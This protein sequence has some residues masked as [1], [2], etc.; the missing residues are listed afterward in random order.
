M[1]PA[2]MNGEI[3]SVVPVRN[4]APTFGRVACFVDARGR[5]ALHRTV[6]SFAILG[7]RYNVFLSDNGRHVDVV[8][9][10]NL[11]GIVEDDAP[12]ETLTEGVSSS[13]VIPWPAP[14]TVVGAGVL[15][16]VSRALL[17]SRLEWLMR[18]IDRLVRRV[19][20][21]VAHRARA[22]R[23]LTRGKRGDTL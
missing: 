10:E 9:R 21:S 1:E 17:P 18:R 3:V 4:S 15:Y 16:L 8:P 7:R 2:I 20:T 14:L 6:G 19:L 5:E 13:R 22:D 23:G 11:I 12:R